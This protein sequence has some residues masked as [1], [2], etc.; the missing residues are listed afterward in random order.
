MLHK[1][2]I[3]I[4]GRVVKRRTYLY[5]LTGELILIFKSRTEAAQYCLN[6][7]LVHCSLATARGRIC[8]V[9]NGIHKDYAGFIWKN[10]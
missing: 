6:Q 1:N 7:D 9:C 4:K 3:V 5:S 10:D 2:N 8:E